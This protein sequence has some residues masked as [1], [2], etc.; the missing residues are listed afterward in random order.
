MTVLRGGRTFYGEAIGI[1]M[2]DTSF[3]RPPGDIGNATTFDFPVRYRI[4]R[5]A[6]PQRVVIEQDPALLEPFVQGARELQQEGV[7]AITTSCGFLALFQREMAASVDVPL[8]TSSLMQMPVVYRMLRP[9]QKIGVLTANSHHL[10]PRVLEAV[11]ASDVPYVV[12]GSQETPV[13]LPGVRHGREGAG[14]RGGGA[15]RREDGLRSRERAPRRGGLRLR[16]HQLQQLRARR[17]GGHGSAVLRHRDHDAM[18]V[19]RG[20]SAAA[21]W[22]DSCSGPDDSGSVMTHLNEGDRCHEKNVDRGESWS[23]R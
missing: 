15:G 17:A 23:R 11:G 7:R 1:L 18:D 5:G 14:L 20:L 9:D 22:A 21:S 13:L 12:S 10:T 8:F 4:V 19:L 6:S 2:L 3:P 16:R